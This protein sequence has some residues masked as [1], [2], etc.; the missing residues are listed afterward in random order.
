MCHRHDQ[1]LVTMVAMSQHYY[2][3]C[4]KTRSVAWWHAC[5]S[6]HFACSSSIFGLQELTQHQKNIEFRF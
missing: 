3:Q 2:H 5:S 6:V 1:D 4:Q